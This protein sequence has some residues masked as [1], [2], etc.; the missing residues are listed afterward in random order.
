MADFFSVYGLLLVGV[1]F[2]GFFAGFAGGMFGVGGG[3][4]TVPALYFVLQSVGVNES[5]SLKSAIGTSLAVILVTSFR[6]LSAHHRAGHADLAM[7]RA[8]ALWIGVGAGC[9]GLAARWIPAALL[10]AIFAAGAFY[11]GWRR[12]SP[13]RKEGQQPVN[14]FRKGLKIPVGLGAGFFSSLMG[15]GGGAVGVMVMTMA[16]RPMHQAVG[17][18]AGFGMAVAAPGAIGF[19]L[20]GWG[21]A[22][23]PPGSLGYVNLPAFL[24]MGAMAGLAAPLGAR[25]A[26]RVSGQLL[27]KIFGLYVVAA[28]A[29]LLW[30]LLWT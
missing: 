11:V 24:V 30:D 28:G 20:S 12:L 26:H 7:L 16:G 3:I 19:I 6:S 4:V 1:V 27:S 14:L 8:W 9:G 2:A 23:L 17:T 25:T 22:G 10:T 13:K 21:A 18:S 15:L 29:A 5:V